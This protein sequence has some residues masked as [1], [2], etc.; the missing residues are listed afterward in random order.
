MERKWFIWEFN[1][2]WWDFRENTGIFSRLSAQNRFNLVSLAF[3]LVFFV[4]VSVY[5]S[6]F[7]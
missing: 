7:E 1:Y 3:D 6:V 4:R 5:L 2:F